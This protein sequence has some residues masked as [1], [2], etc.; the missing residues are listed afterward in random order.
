MKRNFKISCLMLAVMMI[1]IAMPVMAA[2]E[3]TKLEND[4][5]EMTYILPVWDVDGEFV[6]VTMSSC[7]CTQGEYEFFHEH[8]RIGTSGC[9][10]IAQRRCGGCHRDLTARYSFERAPCW[11]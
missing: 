10:G 8:I 1:F 4:I 6:G 9:R 5:I 11:C 7:R 2:E 3:V